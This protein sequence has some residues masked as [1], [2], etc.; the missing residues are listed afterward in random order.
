MRQFIIKIAIFGVVLY[1]LA[2]ALDYTIST[3][4]Y[5][6]EDY[7]FMSWNEMQKGDINADI[8][9]MGNSRA[10]SHFEPWT[11]DSITGMSCYNLGIGGYPINVETMKYHTYRLYNRKPQIIILQVDYLT[12]RCEQTPH[13]H[14]SEQ[15]LPLIYDKRIHPEL[16]RV[17]YTW[18]DL[19]C[20]LY[21]YWGYQVVI[22]NGLMESMGVKHYVNEPSRQG[23]HYET[24]KWNGTELAKMD[25]IHA[26]FD[27]D[28]R[29]YFEAFMQ[30]CA[31]EDIKVLL[32]NSPQYIG[33]IKKTMGRE[34]V[35]AYY[36]SIAAVY[37]T[38]YWNYEHHKLCKDTTNFAVSVHMNSEATHRFSIEFA[39]RLKEC[40]IE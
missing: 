22:K 7:R 10:L 16:R 5:Q 27:E 1:G 15:F 24:A 30:H 29:R 9:I 6:M 32:V 2:W 35:N 40:I 38:R 3:G 28:G 12:L 33:A 13:Q 18:L 20:P 34:V 4:L 25:T 36:D 19:Y 39:N 11:I 21:R 31:D 14:Q 23:M 37:H 8:L 17:G 26:E